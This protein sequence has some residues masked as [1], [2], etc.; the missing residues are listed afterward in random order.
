MSCLS[1]LQD[2]SSW[3]Y[4]LDKHIDDFED[5]V[6]IN[7]DAKILDVAAGTGLVGEKVLRPA[8]YKSQKILWFHS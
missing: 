5:F 1:W 7:K 3:G 4:Y 8:K 2:V 6:R